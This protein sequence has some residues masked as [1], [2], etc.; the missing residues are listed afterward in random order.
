MRKL[1]LTSHA[2]P[3]PI[4]HAPYDLIKTTM[5]LKDNLTKLIVNLMIEGPAKRQG[6]DGV[7]SKLEQS[8]KNLNTRLQTIPDTQS[9]RN[10][11]RHIIAI[12]KWGQRRLK[13]ALGEPLLDDE[14]HTYKPSEQSSWEEL[15][16][17]FGIT[18]L[19]TLAIARKLAKADPLQTVP[20]NQFGPLSLL[21]WLRYLTTHAALESKRMR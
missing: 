15:K 6:L 10:T 13:V 9:N 21:G 19:E 11:L 20:H 3:I 8:A 4:P 16:S 14:N 7:T 12:E 2:F 17:L 1:L 18:R 5:A